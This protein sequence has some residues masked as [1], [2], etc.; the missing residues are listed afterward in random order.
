MASALGVGKYGGEEVWIFLV[1]A[2]LGVENLGGLAFILHGIII[3]QLTIETFFRVY[4]IYIYI[5]FHSIYLW[6][7]RCTKST[8]PIG[9]SPSSNIPPLHHQ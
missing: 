3:E 5:A 8:V 9:T 6:A 4:N 1:G 7:E 2:C